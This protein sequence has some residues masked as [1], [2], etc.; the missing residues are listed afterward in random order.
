[1]DA[2]K[3]VCQLSRRNLL[4]GACSCVIRQLY[5]V[6]CRDVFECGWGNLGG[7]LHSLPC[8]NI[9]ARWD[10]NLHSVSGWILLYSE[11]RRELQHLRAVQGG[12]VQYGHRGES[13]CSLHNL[14]SWDLL[15]WDW[16]EPGVGLRNMPSRNVFDRD[17][18]EHVFRL[19]G[20]SGRNLFYGDWLKS[21]LCLWDMPVWNV[22]YRHWP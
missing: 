4:P 6:Q 12:H 11:L 17:R 21:E 20:V 19:W 8:W 14:P 18:V 3:Q 13:V 22:L 15:D 2:I 5:P 16:A 9:L 10:H 1:M 7:Y